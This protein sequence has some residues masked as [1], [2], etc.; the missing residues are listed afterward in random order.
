[1]FFQTVLVLKSMDC[2]DDSPIEAYIYHLDVC[3]SVGDLIHHSFYTEN[4]ICRPEQSLALIYSS[5][6][7]GF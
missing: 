4:E 5:T 7:K 1:M 6:K 2:D 3:D